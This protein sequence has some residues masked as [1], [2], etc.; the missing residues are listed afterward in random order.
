MASETPQG[1]T[2]DLRFLPF[3]P[4]TGSSY[5]SFYGDFPGFNNDGP[6]DDQSN[7]SPAT[8][9][10]IRNQFVFCPVCGDRLERDS[11][12]CAWCLFMTVDSVV[13]QAT[14][15]PE[16]SDSIPQ[17]LRQFSNEPQAGG[18]P[19]APLQIEMVLDL[20]LNMA[21]AP[22][23]RPH[24]RLTKRERRE[25]AAKRGLVCD[26]CRTKRIKVCSL[27]L[28]KPLVFRRKC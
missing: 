28:L 21:E 19:M 14:A 9:G 16:S 13:E 25:V 22:P 7:F 8:S 20:D 27:S 26:N 1:H 11:T 2:E 15:N 12:E 18:A 3:L 4:P 6:H 24:R 17:E 5:R 10:N 23:R